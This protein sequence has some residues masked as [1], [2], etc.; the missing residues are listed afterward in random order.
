MQ[1]QYN[2]ETE[3]RFEEQEDENQEE[4]IE[5]Y[6]RW[7][8]LGFSV[9][10]STV[11]GGALLFSNLRNAGY[12]KEATFV[13]IFS[14]FYTLIGSIVVNNMAYPYLFVPICFNIVGGMILAT[15]FFNKYFP[16]ND[17]YPKPIGKALLI[18]LL[19]C[20]LLMVII[21]YGGNAL[22]LTKSMSKK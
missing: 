13:L 6:S 18:S 3:E 16:E 11:F 5:I 22:G 20:I 7:A 19:V 21:Y 4:A 2:Q 14:I 15:F 10:F 12:K 9:F 8:I 1:D 17:Y